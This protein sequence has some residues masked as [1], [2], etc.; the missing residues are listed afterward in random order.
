MRYL[1]LRPLKVCHECLAVERV[2]GVA[3][4]LRKLFSGEYSD[5]DTDLCPELRDW[6]W[7]PPPEGSPVSVDSHTHPG[8]TVSPDNQI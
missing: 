2:V 7:W 5:D 8:V 6:T 1:H 3:D 4:C